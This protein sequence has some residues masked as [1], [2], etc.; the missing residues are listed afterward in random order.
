M[1]TLFQKIADREIP[2]KIVFEDDLCFAIEDINP[3]APTHILVIPK[4]VITRLGGATDDDAALLGHLLVCAGKIARE[5]GI[6]ETG[7]RAVINSGKDAGETVPHLHVHI[8]GG[9]PLAWP[10]G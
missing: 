6:A 3:Q 4:R 10:P 2:S 5:R 8:L 7:F 9:R 1:K